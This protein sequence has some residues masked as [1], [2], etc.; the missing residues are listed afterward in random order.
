MNVKKVIIEGTVPFCFMQ[1]MGEDDLALLTILMQ[2]TQDLKI[3]Y[4]PSQV[5]YV[6]SEHGGK[7]AIYA[8]KISGVWSGRWEVLHQLVDVLN[9]HGATFSNAKA[10]DIEDTPSE[11]V[12]LQPEEVARMKTVYKYAVGS[13]QMPKGAEVLCV[14]MQGDQPQIW[15]LVDPEETELESRHFIVF[16]TGHPIQGDYT[17]IGTYQV[18]GGAF[19]G[20]VFEALT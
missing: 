3:R 1:D 5:E 6:P 11:W 14:Q 8:F 20:H 16:G 13:Q 12:D 18:L 2:P 9:R 10:K 15:A 4:S 7:T 19:I 17:Y